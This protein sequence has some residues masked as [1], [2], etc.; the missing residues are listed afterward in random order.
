MQIDSQN[1]NRDDKQ[2][3]FSIRQ[4]SAKG[5]IWKSWS[6][7]NGTELLTEQCYKQHW[8]FIR[9][10]VIHNGA[11]C[12]ASYNWICF[13]IQPIQPIRFNFLLTFVFHFYSPLWNMVDVKDRIMR[14]I[15]TFVSKIPTDNGRLT[16]NLLIKCLNEYK[17]IINCISLC[18]VYFTQSQAFQANFFKSSFRIAS[19][20]F[21]FLA[22]GN[23]LDWMNSSLL[24]WR[25]LMILRWWNFSSTSTSIASKLVHSHMKCAFKS[26]EA[27]N[28]FTHKKKNSAFTS[29]TINGDSQWWIQLI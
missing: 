15:W 28:T 26:K 4:Q 8:F 20:L 22:F 29:M 18:M 23:K 10:N 2:N 1:S 5:L 17:F 13:T 14:F 7:R 19:L 9:P 11:Y 6:A 16:K 21:F 12:V 25:N 3:S 27:Q 24:S